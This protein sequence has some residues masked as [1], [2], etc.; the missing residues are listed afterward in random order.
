[1]PGEDPGGPGGMGQ[2]CWGPGRLGRT[3]CL[4]SCLLPGVPVFFFTVSDLQ[5]GALFCPAGA[6]W[7]LFLELLFLSPYEGSFLP[8]RLELSQ[9]RDLAPPPLLLGSMPT[10]DPFTLSCPP[11]HQQWAFFA[12]PFFTEK[13]ASLHTPLSSWGA[14]EPPSHTGGTSCL[15]PGPR[16]ALQ[17]RASAKWQITCPAPFGHPCVFKVTSANL[18]SALKHHIYLLGFLCHQCFSILG[19]RVGCKEAR[20]FPLMYWKLCSV[21]LGL[22]LSAY[23][24]I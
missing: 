17:S 11:Q 19:S 7:T 23:H 24:C 13:V 12:E 10:S 18:S 15:S 16:S 3:V 6:L 4:Q 20:A 2:A 21:E 9:S 1:M 8:V 5:G 22:S 14:L